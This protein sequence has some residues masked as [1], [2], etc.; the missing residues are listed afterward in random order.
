MHTPHSS[1]STLPPGISGL[2]FSHAGLA[3]VTSLVGAWGAGCGQAQER[4]P[5][6]PQAIRVEVARRGS[7]VQRL[8]YVGTVHSRREVKVMARV[9]GTVVDL[10]MAEGQRARKGVTI[11]RLRARDLAAS[12]ARTSAELKRARSE[13]DYQCRWYKQY[14]SLHAAGTV[15]SLAMSSHR[16]ACQGATAA[17]R[18]ARASLAM[19]GAI[20]SKIRERAP[21]T[22]RVLQWLA[23]PGQNVMPGQPMLLF[24]NDELEVRVQVVESDLR[25][26]IRVGTPVLIRTGRT[27]HLLKVDAVAPMARGLGRTVEVKINLPPS[28]RRWLRNGMSSRVSFV[29]ARETKAVTVSTRAVRRQADRSFIFVVEGRKVRR[30]P[31]KLGV[32]EG[33]WVAVHGDL[34]EQFSVAVSNLEMLSDETRV[35]PVKVQQGQP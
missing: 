8:D 24:G 9:P 35:Y 18:S 26:A 29:L 3:V 13:R 28:A 17:Y 6:A 1:P 10:P 16:R 30:V 33:R 2:A 23:E 12:Y 34:P 14:R 7:L 21:F 22:G 15:S 25:Q 20:A 4:P 5:K 32:R 31:V 27:V 19:R 11:A